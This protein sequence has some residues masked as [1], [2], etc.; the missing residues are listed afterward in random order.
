MSRTVNTDSVEGFSDHVP[1]EEVEME[2]KEDMTYKNGV[3]VTAHGETKCR[4]MP[5]VSCIT[6]PHTLPVLFQ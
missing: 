1:K 4:L 2:K 6:A 5:K 3:L